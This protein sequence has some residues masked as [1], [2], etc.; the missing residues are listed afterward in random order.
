MFPPKAVVAEGA[1][2]AWPWVVPQACGEG[3]RPRSQ[4]LPGSSGADTRRAPSTTSHSPAFAVLP[5]EGE[6]VT[7]SASHAPGCGQRA[8]SESAVCPP[9]PP[10]VV[11]P[12]RLPVCLWRPHAR[13][14][15]SPLPSALHKA[16]ALRP[17]AGAS[18]I[19][20]GARGAPVIV[21]P[22]LGGTVAQRR[23][24]NQ[25]DADAFGEPQSWPQRGYAGKSAVAGKPGPHI[26]RALSAGHVAGPAPTSQVGR[27]TYKG[28]GL[29]SVT[30]PGCRNRTCARSAPL[31]TPTRELPRP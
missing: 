26:C 13:T 14:P 15:R 22:S 28:Q 27:L 7:H 23:D 11:S 6:T 2:R 9:R 17:H 8:Y 30:W 5:Q 16:R 12:P 3:L 20:R 4:P 18:S 1:R 21:P 24:R 25:N 10:P 19:T 31:V 29:A